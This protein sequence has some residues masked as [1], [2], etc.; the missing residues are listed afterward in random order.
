M[1]F[2]SQLLGRPLMGRLNRTA[3]RNAV[4]RVIRANKDIAAAVDTLKKTKPVRDAI[5]QV[6][7]RNPS[8]QAALLQEIT[9]LRTRR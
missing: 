9:K 3:T 2:V 7:N 1:A 5:T 8:I 6:I 4:Q